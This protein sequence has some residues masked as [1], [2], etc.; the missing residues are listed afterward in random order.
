M[1]GNR[2]SSKRK[3]RGQNTPAPEQHYR[4]ASIRFCNN[5]GTRQAAPTGKKC[6]QSVVITPPVAVD[7]TNSRLQEPL[8]DQEIQSDLGNWASSSPIQGKQHNHVPPNNVPASLNMLA[9]TVVLLK[10]TMESMQAELV[11][12][13]ADKAAGQS[14]SWCQ[15]NGYL[16]TS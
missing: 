8:C 5:C 12:I 10:S 9:D 6:A 15:I 2:A 3:T 13:R 16:N 14:D 1:A 7:T 11:A 4:P